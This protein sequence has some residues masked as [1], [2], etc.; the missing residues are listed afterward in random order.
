MPL[1][2]AGTVD[3]KPKQEST[4][5]PA[6]GGPR[7]RSWRVSGSHTCASTFLR[8]RILPFVGERRENTVA[9]IQPSICVRRVAQ[10]IVNAGTR[11]KW[12]HVPRTAEEKTAV[13]EEFLRFG[14][15]RGVIRC[16]DG[17]FVASRSE[18]NNLPEPQSETWLALLLVLAVD[19][20][21]PGLDD[22]SHICQH[23]QYLGR[24]SRRLH[25]LQQQPQ[26]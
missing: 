22:D 23:L 6:D 5:T 3:A 26:C 2:G 16:V 9:V 21:R 4:G 7:Q 15:L 1:S 12:V 18:Q 17:S 14:P 10:P 13:K 8:H 20:M 24:I 19:P 25:C 11:N